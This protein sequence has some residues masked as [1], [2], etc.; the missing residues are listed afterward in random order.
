MLKS[1]LKKEN[2]Y[3][4]PSLDETISPAKQPVNQ[5]KLKPKQ[6]TTSPLLNFPSAPTLQVVSRQ[7]VAD[8]GEVYTNPREVNAMLD[9]VKPETERLDSTFLEPACGTGNFLVEILSRKLAVAARQYQK[10]QLE[11]ERAAVLAIS[12][13]YG[14]DILADNAAV[15]H[16]RLFEVFN[17]QYN[18]HY[19]TK[20]K[21]ACGNTVR[22]IFRRNILQ[23]D[24]LSFKTSAGNPIIFSEW[25]FPF[26]DSRIQ[27]RDY[28]F[29]QMCRSADG[30]APPVKS[31]SPSH[32]LELGDAE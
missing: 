28:L 16:A 25:K 15:C 11:Y 7:R 22:H 27:R 5:A 14:I 31:Y 23:G 26:N 24:T 21:Q 19:K 12:S 4:Q 8:Y 32:F 1:V 30:L 3:P 10:S 17:S 29:E 18:A 13:L 6:K 9:L 2:Y 20:C